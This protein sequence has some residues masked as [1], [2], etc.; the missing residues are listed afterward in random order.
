MHRFS[1]VLPQARLLREPL[2]AKSSDRVPP[3][4]DGAVIAVHFGNGV[5]DDVGF[6]AEAEGVFEDQLAF[7]HSIF[8]VG[9][10]LVSGEVRWSLR[11]WDLGTLQES[12]HSVAFGSF[13]IVWSFKLRHLG[14]GEGWLLLGWKA[15]G[16]GGTRELSLS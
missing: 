4:L 2:P 9:K 14:E 16:S 12:A 3:D 1:Y 8:G 13:R 7:D 5:G 15:C 10:A 11:R 6:L